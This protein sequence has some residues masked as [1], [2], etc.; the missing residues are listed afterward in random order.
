[1]EQVLQAIQA[2]GNLALIAVAVAIYR[3]EIKMVRLETKMG[4]LMK[5]ECDE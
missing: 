3:L 2:G 4:F 5:T 1:M